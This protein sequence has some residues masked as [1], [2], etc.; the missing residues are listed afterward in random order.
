[1]AT[2]N[3]WDGKHIDSPPDGQFN[4]LAFSYM[5]GYDIIDHVSHVLSHSDV[6]NAYV[7][8]GRRREDFRGYLVKDRTEPDLTVLERSQSRPAPINYQQFT[9]I[10]Q[11]C[12]LASD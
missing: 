11:P 4:P 1:L 3:K 8:C 5:S 12:M 10:N 7:Y 6:I 2:A 9:N